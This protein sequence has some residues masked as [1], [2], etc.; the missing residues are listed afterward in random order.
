MSNNYKLFMI[1]KKNTPLLSCIE[2]FLI[3]IGLIKFARLIRELR[4]HKI[5]SSQNSI[6]S[7]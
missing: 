4:E 2:I 7:K 1:S 6:E 5:V 3:D